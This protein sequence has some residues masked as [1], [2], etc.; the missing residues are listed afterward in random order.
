MHAAH[1]ERT[2]GSID[3]Q[4]LRE[5]IRRRNIEGHCRVVDRWILARRLLGHRNKLGMGTQG[6][7]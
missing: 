5:E 2:V 4:P 3:G 7:Q 1:V 6:L